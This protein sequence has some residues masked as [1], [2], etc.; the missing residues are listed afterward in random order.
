MTA[1][2]KVW[3]RLEDLGLL[4]LS[5]SRFPSVATTVAESAVTGSW[6]SHPRAGEIFR[7]AEELSDRR[8]VVVTK[9]LSGKVTFVHRRLWPA[10]LSV[11]T[12]REPW[13]LRGLSESALSVRRI[14]SKMGTVRTDKIPTRHL[15]GKGSLGEGVRE[16]ERRLLVH[17]EE[18]HTESG[19]HAKILE[20]WARWAGRA[21]VPKP[22]VSLAAAKQELE[23]LVGRINAKFGANARLPWP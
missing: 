4:M 6:W 22:R 17:A 21:D 3:E 15:P 23:S 10:L 16:L 19:A 14:V 12:G 5:D 18:V 11:G 1:F 8:D 2:N 20:T 9:L 13:Q 7:A